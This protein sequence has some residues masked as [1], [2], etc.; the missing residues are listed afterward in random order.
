MATNPH[1]E[2]EEKLNWDLSDESLASYPTVFNDQCLKGK[3]ALIS[4]GGTGIGRGIAFLMARCGAN[5]IIC[6]RNQNKLDTTVKGIE[7][8][9]G[10][11]VHSYTTNIR[12]YEQVEQTIA[13][14]WRDHGQLDILV[15]NSGGQFPQP[16]VEFSENG[17]NSV[18]DLNLNGTWYM[19]QQAARQWI[20]N[21][22][23]GNIVNIVAN[24][25]RGMPQVAHTCA[26]RAGVIALTRSVST[27]WAEHNIRVNCVSPGTIASNGFGVYSREVQLRFEKSNPMMR[28]GDVYDIAEAVVYLGSDAG[29]FI[30]GAELTVDGGMQNWG[31]AWPGG[32]PDRFKNI[33][34]E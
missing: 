3:T 26:A 29:K 27:E 4:G 12:H 14:I 25:R 11:A 22:H 6:S 13:D 17:W 1:I 15:N 9:L 5:V 7:K 24:V 31:N 19:M 18:I 20:E 10:K 34:E 21:Q 23:P 30:T 28:L 8:E 33:Y 2:L 32:V 16:A